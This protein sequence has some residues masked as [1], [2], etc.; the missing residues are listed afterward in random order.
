MPSLIASLKFI[1]FGL[2]CATMIPLQILWQAFTR[3]KRVYALALIWHRSVCRLFGLRVDIIGQPASDRQVIFVANHVSYLDIPVLASVLPAS[4]V[5]KADVANWPLFGTLARLQHT[6]FISRSRSMA[7]QE[8]HALAARL[9]DGRDL[10]MFPEGT[11]SDGS[12]VLPFKSSLFGIALDHERTG[13]ISIQPVSIIL[14]AIDGRPATDPGIRDKYAWY[15]DMTMLPHLWAFGKS[16]GACVR[17]HF[18]APLSP[19][20]FAD[21]KTLARACEDAVRQPFVDE[22]TDNA[23][24]GLREAATIPSTDNRTKE[25]IG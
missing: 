16:R 13:E 22:S 1:L 18:H 4:F 7:A 3:G 19:S 20:A 2:L 21:R 24:H 12:R 6:A 10:I 23:L 9:A 15:G 5:A 25:I 17:L 14:T 8:K 11:S